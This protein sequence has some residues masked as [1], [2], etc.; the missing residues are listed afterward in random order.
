MPILLSLVLSTVLVGLLLPFLRRAFMDVPNHRSSHARPV[1]RGGGLAVVA[2]LIVVAVLTVGLDPDVV[3]LLVAT[4][5]LACVGFVD[6]VRSLPSSVRLLAQVV[7]ATGLGVVLLAVGEV[8]WWW[9]PILVVGLAGFV[10]AFNF[11][12]GV[13]G[14]SGLTATAVG[15]WWAWA[16]DARG[17]TT[18]T[19]LGLILA[20]AAIGFLPWNAPR[21]RVFLGDVGSY[22]I[23]IF[24]AGLSALAVADGLPWWWAIAPLVVYGAD[25]GWVLVKRARSGK[26]LTEAHREHVYQRLVDAGWSHVGTASLCAGATVMVCAVTGMAGTAMAWWAVLIG[27]AVVV[28]Y[29]NAARAHHSLVRA[30]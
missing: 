14:I 19:T 27:A 6:D 13:N 10:N 15:L 8:S 16:G 24:I 2:A 12:D 22:G 4:A 29:L 30:S 23:G 25:T 1:P 17:H 26:S 20:G 3:A 9:L 5:L 18:L 7:T 28:A 21:A 11:M